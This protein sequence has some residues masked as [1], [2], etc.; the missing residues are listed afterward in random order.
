[1]T[2]TETADW[3]RARDSYLILTHRRPDGDTIGCAGALAQ[4]LRESGKTAYVLYNPEVTPR[5][6][7]FVKD[8]FAPDEFEPEY[9]IAVDTASGELLPKN[10]GKYKDA[11]SLC[12]DHHPS[13]TLY[14][15]HT[16]LDGAYASCGELIYEILIALSGNI[17]VK[18]AEHLYVALTTDTGCFA[19]ANT[20]AYTLRVASL[21]IEAGA[22][23]RE[24]NRLLF[25]TKT[26]SRIRIEGAIFSGLEFYFD[27][28]VAVSTITRDMIES[29]G[30]NED[31]LDD[32]ASL[33]G[34][35]DG[36][37]V[38]ITV[39]EMT[40]PGN[41]KVSVRT[42]PSVNAS[43]I[44]GRFGGGGHSMAAG[45]TLEKPISEVKSELLAVLDDFIVEAER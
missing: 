6:L 26:R 32:I 30:A 37:R 9:I 21:L 34:V 42:S 25:R 39:R 36:V 29:S 33:P 44:C 14:A 41:C 24:L 27:G 45:Y 40:S 19:F 3:L 7:R 18:S 31:D 28:A 35:V 1:M 43:A 8:Y 38:G 12:I 13:N 22:P 16:C 23:H 15:G 11:V 10:G 20:T 17:S 2:I 4:G 5:Y